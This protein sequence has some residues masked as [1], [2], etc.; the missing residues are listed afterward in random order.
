MRYRVTLIEGD[1]IDKKVTGQ[2]GRGEIQATVLPSPRMQLGC[3]WM[4][5]HFSKSNIN[6]L[7]NNAEDGRTG[8][9]EYTACPVPTLNHSAAVK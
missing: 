3:M 8:T 9:G 4:P 6:H 5:F 2:S 1:G 7:S